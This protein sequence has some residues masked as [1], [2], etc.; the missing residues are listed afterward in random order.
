MQPVADKKKASGTK[1]KITWGITGG[2]G[3]SS[4]SERFI[5]GNFISASA[6]PGSAASA[7]P[8]ALPS[9]RQSISGFAGLQLRKP[10][11]K[12]T[13]VFAGIQYAYSAIKI[14]RGS[15]TSL[16]LPLNGSN[17]QYSSL[18]SY[19]AA[20]TT[21]DFNYTSHYHFL[22]IP[23][24][25]EKQMGQRS[26]FSIYAGFSVAW[27]FATNALQFDPLAKI[28]FRDDNYFNRIQWNVLGGIDYNLLRNEKYSLKI[29]P[30]V[31]YGL[32]SLLNNRSPYSS[33]LFAGEV[34]LL[35]IRNRK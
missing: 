23:L 3:L 35:L 22:E 34:R 2:V 25:I 29:G 19:Y 26:R 4:V 7:S 24:G 16:P 20:S 6:V 18:T 27:L 33:H 8:P 10:L 31:H 13:S 15:L 30:Q 1:N 14:N 32:T 12:T 5:P 9:D 11:N 28:Y 17:A 21:G